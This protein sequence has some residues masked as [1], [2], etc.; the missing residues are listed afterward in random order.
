MKTA[1]CKAVSGG[2]ANLCGRQ[3]KQKKGEG[4]DMEDH[5]RVTTEEE[6]TSLFQ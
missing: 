6:K 4:N 2:E 5:I 3:N 1:E